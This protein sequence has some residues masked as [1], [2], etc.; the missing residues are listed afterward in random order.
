MQQHLGRLDGVAKVEVDLLGGT[1][2]LRPK[3]D[4]RIDPA[5]VLKGTFD[6]GVSL[7]ELTMI[8]TGH[9]VKKDGGLAFEVLPNQAFDVTPNEMSQKLAPQAD[10]GKAIT[11]RGR[12][13][14]KPS[15]K[16]KQ[17]VEGPL[18]LEILD[19]IKKE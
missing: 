16:Q 6:S 1:V 19:V 8:A 18:K 17:K 7:V 14:Q 9:L 13:Y 12:L 5:L 2:V 10:S 3:A 4:G 15:G 11:L